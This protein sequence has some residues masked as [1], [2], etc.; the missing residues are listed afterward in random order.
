MKYEE[1]KYIYGSTK[2]TLSLHPWNRVQIETNPLKHQTLQE[3]KFR[4]DFR[5]S[6]MNS[7]IYDMLNITL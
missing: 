4:V 6:K 1:H 2:T 5:Y 3:Q 7:V